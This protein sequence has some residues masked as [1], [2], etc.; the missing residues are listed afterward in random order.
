MLPVSKDTICYGSA[1]GGKSVHADYPEYNERHVF[2]HRYHRVRA[3]RDAP[4]NCDRCQC[5][6]ERIFHRLNLKAHRVRTR[7]LSGPGDIEGMW[8]PHFIELVRF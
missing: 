7:V 5:R 3:M 2:P 4:L 1:D 6:F 8:A